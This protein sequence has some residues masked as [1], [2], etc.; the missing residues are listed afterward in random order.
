VLPEVPTVA[1][2]GFP[3]YEVATWMGALV[4]AAT[5]RPIVEALNA[6]IVATL[7]EP[8]LKARLTEQMY[9][10]LPSTPE[11]FAR[12]IAEETGK[13]GRVVRENGIRPD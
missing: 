7:R 5:P 9:D 2:L 10:V 8:E 12:Y 1:E 4:P 6:A 11:E 3:G 13:W